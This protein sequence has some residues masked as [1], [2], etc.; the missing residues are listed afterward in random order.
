[1]AAILEDEMARGKFPA[2]LHCFTGGADLARR[3]V[4]IGLYVSFSGIITFKKS[5][6]LRAIAAE[7]PMDRVLVE[8]DAPYLAPEPYRGK[9][10]EPAYVV[11]TAAALA[12]SRA[13]PTRTSP[14]RRPRISS[15]STPRCPAR[16]A[17]KFRG[18]SGKLTH[19]RLADHRA[20]CRASARIGAA[21]ILPTRRT[22]AGAAPPSSS[23]SPVAV[24]H[25]CS[26]TP[27]RTFASSSSM[28]RRRPSTASST[29]TTTPTTRMASM[30][31]G[32]SPTMKRRVDVLFRCAT[33]A[34]LVTRFGYCFEAPAGSMLPADPER[35]PDRAADARTHQRRRRPH[36]GDADPAG[37]WRQRFAR[38]P[39]RRH[40]LLA[41]H[42]RSAAGTRGPAARSLDLWIVDALRYT[43]H[44]EPLHRRAGARVDRAS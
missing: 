21:A 14:P 34:S 35:A 4:A 43:P 11:H 32:C 38:L 26:S 12:G 8:T 36:R 24:R 16:P 15:A 1:M 19:P 28:P 39:V 22:V 33:R 9:R 17:A 3:A 6:A 23:G 41:R 5:D 13:S 42:L 29:R 7:V 20:A 37:A 27:R 40:R 31:C 30:T 25:G 18:M 44:P 2:V 10:N